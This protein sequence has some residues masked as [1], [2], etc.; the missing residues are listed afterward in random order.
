MLKGTAGIV[1][2][3]MQYGGSITTT[4]PAYSREWSTKAAPAARGTAPAPHGA[5]PSAH[6]ALPAA[7]GTPSAAPA[8]TRRATAEQDAWIEKLFGTKPP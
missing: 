1:K 3:E 7:H 5:A 2:G 8:S 4:V 6:G